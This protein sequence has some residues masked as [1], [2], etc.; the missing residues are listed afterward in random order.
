[1]ISK[2]TDSSFGKIRKITS[3]FLKTGT[4]PWNKLF[5]ILKEWRIDRIPF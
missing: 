3:L 1:M 2:G 4:G 5:F